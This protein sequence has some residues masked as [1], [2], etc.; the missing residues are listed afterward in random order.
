M[1]ITTYY[2]R[3]TTVGGAGE[4]R[5]QVYVCGSEKVICI[6]IINKKDSSADGRRRTDL[7]FRHAVVSPHPPP[8]DVDIGI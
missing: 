3:T 4:D 2:T 1:K 8:T 5:V 6:K 7:I